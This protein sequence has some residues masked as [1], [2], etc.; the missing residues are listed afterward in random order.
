M[1]GRMARSRG[2][3]SGGLRVAYRCAWLILAGALP[4]GAQ[5]AA[6]PANQ[7]SPA[8]AAVAPAAKQASPAAKATAPVKH[9]KKSAAK[10]ATPPPPPPPTV[11]PSRFQEPATP[12]V[13]T[14][15]KDQ[16]MVRADNS[17]LSQILHQVSSQTGMQLEGLSGDERVFGSFGPGAT[18][19][20]LTALLDGTGY[21]M[22][23]VGSLP[24]GAPRQLLLS[25]PSSGAAG[26]GA[27][28]AP[29]P[30]PNANPNPNGDMDNPDDQD[31]QDFQEAP[32]P[33]SIMP[34]EPPPGA[35]QPPGAATP[36][37]MM[38]QQM[39]MQN[40]PPQ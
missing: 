20:V 19:E 29:N 35:P 14:A 13:V 9:R 28:V 8:P 16:L 17:S 38:R 34:A 7:P 25:R 11:A 37:E 5:T 21:N 12:A 39:Q 24:N 40:P 22:M 3:L 33:P 32:S 4:L 18:R 15:G 30:N 23:M 6:P 36:Q 31:P 10:P 26:G 27:V 2:K 1:Y